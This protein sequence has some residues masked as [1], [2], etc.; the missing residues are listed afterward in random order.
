MAMDGSLKLMDCT[1]FY[2]I[3]AGNCGYLFNIYQIIYF[4]FMNLFI[5]LLSI[6]IRLKSIDYI[7]I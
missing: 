2:A 6:F 5:Q 4:I 7:F 3:S 1:P